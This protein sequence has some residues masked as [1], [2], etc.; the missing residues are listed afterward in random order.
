MRFVPLR[1]AECDLAGSVSDSVLFR[2]RP[3]ASTVPDCDYLVYKDTF[4]GCN[5]MRHDMAGCDLA[6]WSILEAWCQM[7]TPPGAQQYYWWYTSKAANAAVPRSVVTRNTNH[8]VIVV[9][10]RKLS[11]CTHRSFGNSFSVG[12][13]VWN[14]NC[15]GTSFHRCDQQIGSSKPLHCH[16]DS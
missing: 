11:V 2:F 3:Q 7:R 9:F 10:C 15:A 6:D 5:L 16:S 14:G 1:L 4:A 13:S 8:R 12:L